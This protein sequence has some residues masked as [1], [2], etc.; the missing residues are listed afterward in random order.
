[1]QSTPGW[2]GL[3]VTPES[4][5]EVSNLGLAEIAAAFGHELHAAGLTVTPQRSSSFAQSVLLAKPDRVN[6]L[7]WVARATLVSSRDQIPIFDQVF[8]RV[9]EGIFN[10]AEYRQVDSAT[11]PTAEAGEARDQRG[12]RES[13][14]SQ[15]A[16]RITSGTPGGGG[17]GESNSDASALA[18]LS[19]QERINERPF[20]EL[21]PAELELIREL[22]AR[23][24]VVPPLRKGRRSRVHHH[25]NRWDVRATLRAAHRTGGDPV[26]RVMRERE[27]RPRKIVLLADVSGSMEPYS[28]IYLHLMRGAVKSIDAEAFVFATRLTRI[29][30][31]LAGTFPE[32]AYQQVARA[33]FDWS[34]GTRIG[35]SLS[36]FLN[37]FGRRGMARGAVIVIV[38]DGWETGDPREL[39]R[40][41]SQ[42]ARLAHHVIWVNPRKAATDYRP[43]VG[44]MAAAMPYIN[45]FLSGHS[46]FALT[47]VMDAISQASVRNLPVTV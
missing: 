27:P 6:D 28:R 46:M 36:D 33:A 25:G 15:A 4:E 21:T 35:A 40:A 11:P 47:D 37:R 41:M 31:A 43:L 34:G 12:D 8:A 39:A 9:F 7:Y 42:L 22:V 1:M 44:G 16:P 26:K 10:L 24:P 20:S 18:A 19:A 23:L 45:T 5:L 17:A 3:P 13:R 32:A 38:S 14:E 29:T 2:L 30:R